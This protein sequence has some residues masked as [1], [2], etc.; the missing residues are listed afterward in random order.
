MR[1]FD[2]EGD[3]IIYGMEVMTY[4]WLGNDIAYGGTGNDNFYNIWSSKG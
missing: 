3:D 4:G 1:I 2:T